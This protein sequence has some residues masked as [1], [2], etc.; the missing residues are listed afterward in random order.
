M[1]GCPPGVAAGTRAGSPRAARSLPRPD[2]S[3]HALTAPP[4]ALTP[5]SASRCTTRPSVGIDPPPPLTTVKSTSSEA[6][7][8]AYTTCDASATAAVT[9]CGPAPTPP[10]TCDPLS[11]TSTTA[12]P[13]SARWT[14]SPGPAATPDHDTATS[15]PT[16]TAPSAGDVIDTD[17][18]G[19]GGGPARYFSRR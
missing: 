14:W 3:A 10:N 15:G 7:A 2:W 16:T 12:P 5:A 4:A 9:V 1:A 8:F 6:S 18:T 19:G 11:P 13:S 17:A